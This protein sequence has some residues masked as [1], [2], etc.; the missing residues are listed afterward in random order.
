[1]HV[2]GAQNASA[3]A[4]VAECGGGTFAPGHVPPQRKEAHAKM[5]L[6]NAIDKHTI[7]MAVST[8]AVIEANIEIAFVCKVSWG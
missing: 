7:P 2:N 8:R 5:V 1:V 3:V 6:E 4:L